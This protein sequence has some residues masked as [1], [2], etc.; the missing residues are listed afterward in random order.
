MSL[1]T[2]FISGTYPISLLPGA[3]SGHLGSIADTYELYRFTELMFRLHPAVS[4]TGNQ[5]VAYYP[6]VTDTFPSTGTT[7]MESLNAATLGGASTVPTEWVR[8][9][10]KDLQTYSPWL[11]TVQGTPEAALEVQGNIQLTGPGTDNFLFEMR[12]VCEFKNPVVASSTPAER[13]AKALEMRRKELLA[14]LASPAADT[15]TLGKPKGVGSR[16]GE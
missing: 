1:A 7:N 12:G 15:Q 11:K 5:T 4:R 9:K 3:V 6:G 8:L 10:R 16:T 2:T 14:I 13:R